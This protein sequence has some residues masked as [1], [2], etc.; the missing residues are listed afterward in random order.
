MSWQPEEVTELMDIADHNDGRCDRC[1][2]IIQIYKYAAN[3]Q[4]AI[5]LRRMAHE[6]AV[7]GVNDVDFNTLQLPYALG[8]QRTKM[9]LHGLIAKVK[10]DDGKH[11]ASHW[12][13]TT[14][15]GDWLHGQPISEKVV[16]FDNQVIG[17]DGGT[18]T[19][20]QVS[21]EAA[22]PEA[23]KI[24]TGEAGFLHNVRQPVKFMMVEA[25]YMGYDTARFKHHESYKLIIEKLTVGRPV[26]IVHDIA[27]PTELKMEYKDINAFRKQ[28]HVTGNAP[29]DTE[30]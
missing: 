20:Q 28:W 18:V 7:S 6:V 19:I 8:S 13:I 21:G 23:E 29:K 15:G 9:R 12:L 4:M 17:H 24:S 14:K 1:K 11:V 25:R 30:Q 3:R 26:K 22:L 2:R 27:M 5:I 10:D 16:V